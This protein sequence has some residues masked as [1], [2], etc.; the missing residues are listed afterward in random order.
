MV[1]TRSFFKNILK[2]AMVILTDYQKTVDSF[3]IFAVFSLI[4][5]YYHKFNVT[6]KSTTM[7]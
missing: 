5:L 7:N 1:M 4:T 2:I 3:L 6:T